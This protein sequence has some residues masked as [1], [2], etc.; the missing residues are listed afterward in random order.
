MPFKGGMRPIL[1][2][3]TSTWMDL[4]VPEDQITSSS[5]ITNIYGSRCC[6]PI[7]LGLGIN[8]RLDVKDLRNVESILRSVRSYPSRPTVVM[9]ASFSLMEK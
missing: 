5:V 2:Q 8:D 4:W 6:G 7:I 1:T 3:I 9:T